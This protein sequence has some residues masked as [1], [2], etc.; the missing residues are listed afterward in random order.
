MGE[1][2]KRASDDA[3]YIDLGELFQCLKHFWW[4]ILIVTVLAGAVGFVKSEYLT[5]PT[6]VSSTSMYVLANA[7]SNDNVTSGDFNLGSQISNDLSAMVKSRVVLQAVIDEMNLGMSYDRLYAE[8][9]VH[10]PSN[11]NRLVNI[12]VEDSS[13]ERAMLL[14]DAIREKASEHIKAVMRMEAVSVVDYAYYPTEA[15][16]RNVK[17]NILKMAFLGFVGICGLIVVLH[18]LNDRISTTEEAE[19]RLGITCLAAIPKDKHF[20]K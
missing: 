3:I 1:E 5:T 12:S 17:K 11:S 16:N 2:Q 15:V 10:S 7:N 4:V 20:A 8:V 13:A 18:L 9:S 6:Y 14:A 19:R